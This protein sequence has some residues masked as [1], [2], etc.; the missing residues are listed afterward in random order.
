M[1]Y[2]LYF[3]LICIFRFCFQVFKI[4]ADIIKLW[5][6]LFGD[7]C[8]IFDK[9]ILKNAIFFFRKMTTGKENKLEITV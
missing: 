1:N 7:I 3:P 6:L 9:K 5:K 2:H 8:F 4:Y